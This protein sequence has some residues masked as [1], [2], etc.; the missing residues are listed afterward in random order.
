KNRKTSGRPSPI[1]RSAMEEA[2]LERFIMRREPRLR[3]LEQV[4]VAGID[5]DDDDDDDGHDQRRVVILA[6]DIE[7]PAEALIAAKELGRQQRLPRHAEAAAHRREE[8]GR[9][10]RQDDQAEALEAAMAEA[11]RH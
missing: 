1:A 6:R 2:R 7:E 5:R 11:P 3:R 4:T 8:E 10:R 9:Q